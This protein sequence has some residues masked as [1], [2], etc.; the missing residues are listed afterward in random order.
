MPRHLVPPAS[1]TEPPLLAATVWAGV[2][3]L[4]FTAGY[5]LT[6]AHAALAPAVR[7]TLPWDSAVPFWAWTIVPYLS[8]NLML[9][10]ALFACADRRALHALGA[11][12]LAVMVLSFAVFWAW[13][14][15][16]V[17]TQPPVGL[18]WQPWFDGLR[19]FEAPVN[20]VPSLH[21]AVLVLVWQAMRARVPVRLRGLWHGWCALVAWSTLATWQHGRVGAAAGAALGW[22]AGQWPRDGARRLA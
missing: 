17:H 13:P 8:L 22:L 11:R 1:S 3:G 4:V 5:R 19:A 16:S 18:P 14:T 7:M 15:A 12:V 2:L 21:V 10:L 20:Q 9:P 6:N